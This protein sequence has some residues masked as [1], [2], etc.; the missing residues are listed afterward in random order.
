VTMSDYEVGFGRPPKQ[1]QFKPGVSG[2]SAGRPPR[3]KTNDLDAMI[4]DVLNAPVRHQVDG[5]DRTTPAW[6]LNLNILIQ[7]A[8][9]GDIDAAM[10]VLA[11]RT[12]A[13]R[14]KSG[15]QRIEVEDWLPDYPCQTAEE[16]TRDFRR[17]RNSSAEEWW[18][19][20]KMSPSKKYD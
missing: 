7:R 3:Q 6:E 13:E 2:N 14:S 8:V 9:R 4:L 17:K 20:S 19:P 16:K 10:A 15:M 11:F 5:H 1:F 12:R 18:R